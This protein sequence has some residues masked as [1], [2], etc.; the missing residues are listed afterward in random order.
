MLAGAGKEEIALK[1]ECLKTEDYAV[2]HR[3]LDVRTLVLKAT[4]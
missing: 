1:E 2:I 4:E 3:A